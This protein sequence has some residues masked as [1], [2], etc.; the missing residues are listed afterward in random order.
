[1]GLAHRTSGNTL[2]DIRYSVSFSQVLLVAPKANE[3]L[4]IAAGAEDV[5]EAEVGI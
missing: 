4:S 3:E 5:C 2:H 1:M